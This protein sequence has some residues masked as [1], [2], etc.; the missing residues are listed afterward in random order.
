MCGLFRPLFLTPLRRSDYGLAFY[1]LP[2]RFF[3]NSSTRKAKSRIAS[4]GISATCYM[5]VNNGKMSPFSKEDRT[6]AIS[7]RNTLCRDGKNVVVGGEHTSRCHFYQLTLTQRLEKGLI[8]CSSTSR[9]DR[10]Q[11]DGDFGLA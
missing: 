9:L 6:V 3:L 4:S 2:F 5:K 8:L 1:Y 11:A 10:M 7:T